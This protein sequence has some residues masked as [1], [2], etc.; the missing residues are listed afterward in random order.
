MKLVGGTFLRGFACGRGNVL[1]YPERG[2]STSQLLLKRRPK[3]K[4]IRRRFIR[5]S[6]SLALLGVA[7]WTA[8]DTSDSFL[9][10]AYA[11][12]RC[13]TIADAVIRDVIDYKQTLG[14]DY[15]TEEERIEAQ[16]RCHKRSAERILEAL[17][18]NGGAYLTM[19]CSRI[20]KLC[21]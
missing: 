11:V 1:P 10:L 15:T 12:Q 6:A 18:H 4:R 9:H 17:Q 2:F 20:L 16:S 14:A 21:Q 19:S 13:G 5:T 8:S 7:G 3:S